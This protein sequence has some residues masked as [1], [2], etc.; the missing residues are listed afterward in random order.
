MG[1]WGIGPFDDDNASDWVWELQE[2]GDWSVVERALRGAARVDANTYLEAPDG[3]LAWAAAAVVAVLD[4]PSVVTVP[5]EVTAWVAAH[6]EARPP[7]LR[8]LALA[9]IQRVL[10][11]KSEL[12]ELWR[13]ADEP[14]WRANVERLAGLLA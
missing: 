4:D 3:Q 14:E 1:T 13:E 6:Q 7:D 5:D 11:D 10:A 12:E 2:A 8:S 9:A